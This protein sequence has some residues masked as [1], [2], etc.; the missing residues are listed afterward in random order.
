MLKFILNRS[1]IISVF[2]LLIQQLIVAFST[3]ILIKLGTTEEFA[4]GTEQLYLLAVFVAC[5]FIVYVPDIIAITF[6]ENAKYDAFSMYAT[7]FEK[8]YYGQVQIYNN[9]EARNDIESWITNESRVLIDE[10]AVFLYDFISLILNVSLNVLVLGFALNKEFL[11]F[12]AL[13]F[14]FLYAVVILSN[15]QIAHV[16]S[17]F[18]N[19][20][21]KLS[22]ILLYCW[23][24]ITIGNK[25]SYDQWID[26]LNKNLKSNK[27]AASAHQLQLKMF[28][29]S[30]VIAGLIP[31]VLGGY[32]LIK[33]NPNVLWPIIVTLHR[34]V[35]IVQHFN[36]VA[37]YCLNIASLNNRAKTCVD[38]LNPG[39]YNH[40]LIEHIRWHELQFKYADAPVEISDFSMLLDFIRS[41]K[42]GRLTIMGT[43]GTGK[44]SLMLLLKQHYANDALYLPAHDQ[45]FFKGIDNTTQ[46]STGKAKIAQ[47]HYVLKSH[48]MLLL[49]EWNA[50]LDKE[51][52][53]ILDK[54]IDTYSNKH[55]V[56]EIKHIN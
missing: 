42:Q 33:D 34:Q 38:R 5:L 35:T 4:V 36:I 40:Q 53:A 3:F 39:I 47:L 11:L 31:I 25:P 44:S 8:N 26:V 29:S 22:N 24:N 16:A 14:L 56:I 2:F 9:K 17:K 55:F 15:K 46:L 10:Y 19:A 32:Y 12:Y 7:K 43:N 41:H 52:I 13:G 48:N 51:N 6:L 30:A 23:D 20:R 49:D 28:S 27:I 18:Q 45:L 21:Q 50:N 54:E 1:F 37:L